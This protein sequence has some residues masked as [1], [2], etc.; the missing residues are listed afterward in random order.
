MNLLFQDANLLFQYMNLL[1]QVMILLF[2]VD[3]PEK[4]KLK[5]NL[6][7]PIALPYLSLLRKSV[8]RFTDSRDMTIS[9]Y[10]GRKTIPPQQQLLY[11][12]RAQYLI[13]PGSILRFLPAAYIRLKLFLLVSCLY[14]ATR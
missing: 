5:S 7:S 3:L 4:T 14:P 1:F 6:F 9:V 10:R 12:P 13:N 11:F 8:V 2:Q